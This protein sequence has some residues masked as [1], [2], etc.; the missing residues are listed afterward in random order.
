[1]AYNTAGCSQSVVTVTIEAPPTMM[2]SPP[3]VPPSPSANISVT[4]SS[5]VVYC[6]VTGDLDQITAGVW[7]RDG[8]LVSFFGPSGDVYV[9]NYSLPG[10]GVYTCEIHFPGLE[11]IRV[12]IEYGPPPVIQTTPTT[13]HQ[14]PPA[15]NLQAPHTNTLLPTPTHPVTPPLPSSLPPHSPS[16]TVSTQLSTPLVHCIVSG[17]TSLVVEAVWLVDG[18]VR[19]QF[20]V[21][22]SHFFNIYHVTDYGVYTCQ[23][24]LSNGDI[25]SDSVTYEPPSPSPSPSP[26]PPSVAVNV[27]LTSE[28][29]HC[30]LEGDLNLVVTAMWLIQNDDTLLTSVIDIDDKSKPIAFF[31]YPMSLTATYTC[32]I[33]LSDDSVLTDSIYYERPSP[34]PSPSP[35]PPPAADNPVMITKIGG[36]IVCS[37][38]YSQSQILRFFIL[39][40]EVDI[41]ATPS[42]GE[43]TAVITEPIIGTGLYVCVVATRDSIFQDSLEIGQPDLQP[44]PTLPPPQ[45]LVAEWMDGD[46]GSHG[47]ILVN[48]EEPE[49]S[50]GLRGYKINWDQPLL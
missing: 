44:C 30:V 31:S 14:A 16:V 41:H 15:T 2:T 12:S 24:T 43:S 48:W 1:M 11:I 35:T 17:D 10:Y 20:N 38:A 49:C 25:V 46:D 37:A 29:V 26:S 6:T 9:S 42:Y 32:Y 7:Y 18:V 36:F 23:L 40:M 27:Q 45:F 47:N 4:I 19:S 13:S 34:S 33:T 8:D 28:S 50:D 3:T 5:D 39:Y 21:E 22:T